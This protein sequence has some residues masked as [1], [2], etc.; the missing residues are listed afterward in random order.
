MVPT[1]E[2][3]WLHP[4]LYVSTIKSGEV[5]ADVLRG[6]D[7]VIVHAHERVLRFDNIMPGTPNLS[8]EAMIGWWNTPGTGVDAYPDLPDLVSGRATGRERDDQITCF[9]NNVG[10]GLQ[11]AA[12]GAVI[13]EKANAAGV[14]H[15]L[16]GEWFTEAVHP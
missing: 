5:D 13:L 12:L 1:I 2:L 14:G 10:L 16:P 11:F 9:V 15:E 4:G 8:K 6:C 7:R 3:A